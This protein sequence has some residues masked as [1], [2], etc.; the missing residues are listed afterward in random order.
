MGAL[1]LEPPTPGDR[2]AVCVAAL[3]LLRAAAQ[4][5]PVLA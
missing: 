5:R 2:L 3:G 4:E 1:A